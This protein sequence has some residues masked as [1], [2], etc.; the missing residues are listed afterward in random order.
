MLRV[1]LL[2][3]LAA[4]EPLPVRPLQEGLVLHAIIE[5]LLHAAPREDLL[6]VALPEVLLPFHE[7][8]RR[9]LRVLGRRSLA[10]VP[11]AG[12]MLNAPLEPRAKCLARIRGSPAGAAQR[13]DL[14]RDD[15]AHHVRNPRLKRWLEP[16]EV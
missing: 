2:R 4:P 13:Q 11:A 6:H 14:P 15:E 12:A 9:L 3:R 7:P 16:N 5:P 10:H 1:I 8:T